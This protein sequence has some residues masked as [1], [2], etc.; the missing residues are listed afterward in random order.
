MDGLWLLGLILAVFYLLLMPVLVLISWSRSK[1]LETTVNALKNRVQALEQQTASSPKA[2]P[3]AM[4]VT[5]APVSIAIAPP[6][7]AQVATPVEAPPLVSACPSEPSQ[8]APIALETIAATPFA[9]TVAPAV[10]VSPEATAKNASR[11]TEPKPRKILPPQAHDDGGVFTVVIGWFLRGNPL[12]KLG[13]LLLFFGVAFLLKVAVDNGYFPIQL[14]LVACGAASLGVLYLGWRLRQRNPVYALILQGGAVGILYL[15]SFAAFHLYQLL[16]RGLVFVLLL[17]ICAASVAL[18]VL[19]RAQSL[20][21]MASVGGYLAPILLA[22]GGGNYI[23][24]FSYYALLSSGIMAISFWRAWRPL[25]LIGFAFTFGVAFAWGQAQFQP[26]MYMACQLF[27]IFNLLLFGLVAVLYAVHRENQIRGFVDATLVFGS[28]LIGFGLQY[29]MTRQW[30]FGPAFAAL[31]FAAVYLPVAL[32]LFQ[33][34][35][36]EGRRL[37][38]AFLALGLAFVTLA[39]PLALS[40]Q[41]TAIAWALE[42]VGLLW[43]GRAQNSPRMAWSGSALLLAALCAAIVVYS[44]GMDQGSFLLV[45]AMLSMTWLLA[46]W[47]WRED[48]KLGP[49][50]LL[51]VGGLLFWLWTAIEG[52]WRFGDLHDYWFASVAQQ[53]H[54]MLLLGVLII[55]VSTL[56]W[57]GLSAR[58]CWGELGYAPWLLWLLSG[59]ALAWQCVELAH[60][61][62]LGV[63]S[64]LWLPVPVIAF[65]QLRRGEGQLPATIAAGL[66]VGLLWLCL[67]FVGAETFWFGEQL[68]FASEEWQ[69]SLY[70]LMAALPILLCLLWQRLALWPVRCWPKLYAGPVLWP[71]LPLL[72]MLLL[73]GNLLDGHLQ[74]W[75]YLPLLNPLEESALFA[76]L[77]LLL[78]LGPI[79]PRLQQGLLVLLVAWWGNGVLLRSVSTF[80]HVPWAVEA[81]WA[82]RLVQAVLALVWALLALALMGWGG[83]RTLRPVWLVGAVLLAVVIFKLFLVDSASGGGLM[84]AA[85]FIGVAILVLLIGYIAPIPPRKKEERSF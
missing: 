78:W 12:A 14:R 6:E 41:W 81:L 9:Q 15:T 70:T 83:R 44:R 48:A 20:A 29:G 51:L 54:S 35:P 69:F 40:Q 76:G 5:A 67:L 21:I 66:H 84:R 33:R 34:W 3:A 16:P 60:P 38:Q 10:A 36:G 50:Y 11:I 79:Q 64:W 71:L 73:A 30:A 74:A 61:L 22:D 31:G 72:A 13:I 49:T 42:G 28:P 43:V 32:K 56:L 8:A 24:L 47:L 1:Q 62:A 63:W 58:L 80:A 19:Q 53:K 46:S 55:A 25:N 7:L 57:R 77:T 26:S 39:I 4:T 23:G 52:C 82:S 2:E 75:S 85:T 17:V 68:G 59:V 18:A 37:A 45:F 65:W 27:L